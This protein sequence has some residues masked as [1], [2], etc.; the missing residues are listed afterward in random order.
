MVIFLS[1]VGVLLSVAM[2]GGALL[3][4]AKMCDPTLEV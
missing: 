3:L 2:L 4:L 1:I